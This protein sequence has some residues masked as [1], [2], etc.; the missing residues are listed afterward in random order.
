MHR[1]YGIA[2]NPLYE[3]GMG[4]VGCMPCIHST[5]NELRE[6]AMRF[7]EEIERVAE[8]ERLA[9]AASKQGATTWVDIRNFVD[10]DA[11]DVSDITPDEHGIKRAIEWARTTRGGRQFDLIHA[12][13]IDEPMQCASVYGLC[14]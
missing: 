10:M 1:R 4:R 2:W 11:Y 8:W 13:K 6:I 12:A 5:K 14:E 3:Q 9:S 7:P